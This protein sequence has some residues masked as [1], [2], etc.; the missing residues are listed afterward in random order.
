MP[1]ENRK[2]RP[3]IIEYERIPVPEDK[4]K[5]F[6]T[7]LAI[8]SSEHVAATE[9]LIG[10]LFIASGCTAFDVFVGLLIGNTLAVLSWTFVTA[11]IAVKKRLTL[12][13][14]I[15]KIGGARLVD[16]YNLANG[17]LWCFIGAAMI[18]VSAT[19]VCV[20]FKIQMPTLEDKLP[21]T[22]GLV[23][24]VFAVGAVISYIAAKGYDAIARFAEVSAPWMIL[25]FIL[26]GIAAMPGLGIH[27]P[28]DFWDKAQNVIWKG[29]EPVAGHTKFTIWHV[30][31]FSWFGNIAWHLGMGDLTLFRYA[32]KYTYGFASTTGMYLGHYVAWIACGLFY[33]AQITTNP[34]N[35]GISPGPMAYD[36]GGIAGILLVLFSGWTTANPVIYRAGLAFQSLRPKWSRFRVTLI[37][38]LVATFLAIFPALC[39]DFLTVAAL[40]GLILMPMGAV[41]F[42]DFYLLKRLGMSEFYAEKAGLSFYA[43]P[44]LAWLVS[45][46]ACLFLNIVFKVEVFFLA[47]P[48]WFIAAFLYIILS[49]IGQNRERALAFV[50]KHYRLFVASSILSII[51]LVITALMYFFDK[52]NFQN[53]KIWLLIG[54]IGWFATA[55]FWMTEKGK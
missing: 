45:L 31:F 17:T 46:A 44:L 36:I 24:I 15:E 53:A 21:N 42:I 55:P 19:A 26:L 39:N 14:Q 40:Y 27:S 23:V 37:A 43:P 52:I 33:A 30:I 8:F 1:E 4:T 25:M 47:L 6:K 48:G 49:K 38:G 20:P 18:Y 2:E 9:L 54:T 10:S 11:P 16:I 13:Y 7:F 35:T 12:Y 34:K 41:I 29:G 28:A 22:F 3:E 5:P 32:K 50:C 51:V